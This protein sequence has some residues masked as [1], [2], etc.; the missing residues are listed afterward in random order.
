MTLFRRILALAAVILCV[1]AVCPA[2]EITVAAAA[3]LNFVMQDL[4]SDF[5]ARTGHS[6]RAVF[7]SSG[8]FLAQIRN[9]APF[10]VFLSADL[11]YP[12]QLE[13]LGL[14]EPGSVYSYAIG[15]LVVWAPNSLSN[16]EVRQLGFETLLEP[17]MRQ[18][19]IANPRHAPYGRAA[20]AAL[21]HAR[22][23]DRVKPR[24]VFAE[25]IAQ[26]AHFLESGNADAGLI[27]MSVAL[28]PEMQRKGTFWVVPQEFYPAIEQ[29]AVIVRKTRHLEGARAFLDYLKSPDAAAILQRYGFRIPAAKETQ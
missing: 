10:D 7:G 17:G 9:G 25:N 8:N 6:V 2:D 19:A 1:A 24:L 4:S 5:Q 16:G 12:R 29:G 23:Y 22:I 26:A 20:V 21:K 27:A 11:S 28:A 15:K 13:H 14:A 18:V 3:D